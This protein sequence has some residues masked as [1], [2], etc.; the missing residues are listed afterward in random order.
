MNTDLQIR[1]KTLFIEIVV[2]LIV[3]L[4]FLIWPT[5]FQNFIIYV[6]GGLLIIIGIYNTYIFY[7]SKSKLD[8]PL[9]LGSGVVLLGIILLLLN[10]SI[11]KFIPIIFGIYLIIR[12]I[13]KVILNFVTK[14]IKWI[15]NIIFGIIIILFGIALIIFNGQEIIGYLLGIFIFTYAILDII[16]LVFLYKLKDPDETIIEIEEENKNY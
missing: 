6:V 4:S 1:K 7:K 12:G 3:G 14:D 5:S 16:S 11:V 2:E 9:T 15:I 13:S 10:N 8:L